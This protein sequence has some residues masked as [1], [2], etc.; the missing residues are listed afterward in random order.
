MTSS[1]GDLSFNVCHQPAGVAE[2][3][4]PQGVAPELSDASD[5]ESVMSAQ[6][7]ARHR[8]HRLYRKYVSL[9]PGSEATGFRR[10]N[11]H[12]QRVIQS[13]DNLAPARYAFQK[14]GV[15]E[16][17]RIVYQEQNPQALVDTL[18]ADIL[19]G[20]WSCCRRISADAPGCKRGS[21]SDT[22]LI[23]VRCGVLYDVRKAREAAGICTY[24]PGALFRSKAGGVWWQ[25]C[26][27]VGFKNSALHSGAA[28]RNGPQELRWG[29]R[30]DARHRPL[31][32]F[33]LG[34]DGRK[35]A[36]CT[37][38]EA[39]LSERHGGETDHSHLA[40]DLEWAGAGPEARCVRVV[41]VT[42]I[43]QPLLPT[44]LGLQV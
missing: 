16:L 43:G 34:T 39:R 21:H 20:A 7:A 26:G 24:H 15:E 13:A 32:L 30:T 18:A 28:D 19:T 29:C 41:G 36:H 1:V 11:A 22:S 5:G 3:G 17:N 2:A 12:L 4:D 44:V 42:A 27:A 40:S 9:L 8:T 25:C 14:M 35:Y 23:C 37:V 33:D 6:E 10:E 38:G 31:R